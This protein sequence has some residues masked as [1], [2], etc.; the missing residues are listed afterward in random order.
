MSSSSVIFQFETRDTL[1]VMTLSETNNP[2][3]LYKFIFDYNI[4]NFGNI[5]LFAFHSTEKKVKQAWDFI[6]KISQDYDIASI[7]QK[8][9][10]EHTGEKICLKKI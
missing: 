10:T 7:V 3:K 9:I 2:K 6:E 4:E 8:F 5:D 1:V